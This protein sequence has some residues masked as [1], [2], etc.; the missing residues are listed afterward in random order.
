MGLQHILLLGTEE[1]SEGFRG[2]CIL[3]SLVNLT[4]FGDFL[5]RPVF[6]FSYVEEYDPRIIE[7][8]DPTLLLF[9]PDI[10]TKVNLAA[11]PEDIV[12]TWGPGGFVVP[13]AS[14][15]G[16]SSGIYAISIGG[17]LI[18]AVPEK[19]D[20]HDS[21]SPSSFLHWSQAAK[22]HTPYHRLF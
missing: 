3:G 2:P 5:Q 17:G 19:N 15:A 20:G 4:C 13:D 6:A 8:H 1:W 16:I 9:G 10:I 12:D 11:S 7:K 18:L 22:L 14:A 21:A